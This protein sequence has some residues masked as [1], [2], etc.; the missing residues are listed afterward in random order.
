MTM[1]GINKQLPLC[2]GGLP[3]IALALGAGSAAG[4]ELHNHDICHRVAFCRP[5]HSGIAKVMRWE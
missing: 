4:Q 5:I 2:L 3:A 1:Q